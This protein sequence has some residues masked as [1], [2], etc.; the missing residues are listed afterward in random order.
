MWDFTQYNHVVK[1][2]EAVSDILAAAADAIEPIIGGDR[3][4][5]RLL[6]SLRAAVSMLDKRALRMIAL[7][8]AQARIYVRRGLGR[9]PRR[10]FFKV[11]PPPARKRLSPPD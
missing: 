10:D 6:K 3:I 8:D 11:T 1:R 5:R 2:V 7:Y 9:D 4:A